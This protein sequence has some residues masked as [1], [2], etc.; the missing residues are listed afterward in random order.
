MK[1]GYESW[2]IQIV[3]SGGG[4]L[5]TFDF[6]NRGKGPVGV[7]GIAENPA[8]AVTADMFVERVGGDVS[9]E[10]QTEITGATTVFDGTQKGAGKIYT[11]NSATA[12]TVQID[13]GDYVENDVINTERRGLGTVEILEGTNVRFQGVRDVN[14]RY[15]IADPNSMAS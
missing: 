3:D 13:N 7:E 6:V 11:F 1:Q 12:Q 2:L 5:K 4:V 14:G 8:N 15:F 9:I 10:F